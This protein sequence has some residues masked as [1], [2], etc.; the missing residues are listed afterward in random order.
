[1]KIFDWLT[2][3]HRCIGCGDFFPKGALIT[4]SGYESSGTYCTCCAKEIIEDE[5][6]V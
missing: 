1:M 4:L 3:G 6:E 2:D 5:M